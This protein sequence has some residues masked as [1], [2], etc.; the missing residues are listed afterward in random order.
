MY[1][2]WSEIRIVSPGFDETGEVSFAATVKNSAEWKGVVRKEVRSR[3]ETAGRAERISSFQ[4]H[5][6]I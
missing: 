5:Q 2:G 6:H 4:Y 1:L 3:R